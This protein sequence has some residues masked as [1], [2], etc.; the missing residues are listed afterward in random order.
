MRHF[1]VLPFSD[2]GILISWGKK[3]RK[4]TQLFFP[5]RWE[6]VWIVESATRLDVCVRVRVSVSACVCV[7]E[8]EARG[9]QRLHRV[10]WIKQRK[11][12]QTLVRGPFHWWRLEQ[13]PS[14]LSHFTCLKT[15]KEHLASAVLTSSS[16]PPPL[17]LRP[18]HHHHLPPSLFITLLLVPLLHSVSVP[19]PRSALI[20]RW[21]SGIAAHSSE[22]L[23]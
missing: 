20:R 4:V 14:P 10:V 19:L 15:V 17:L 21:Q 22:S 6:I 7:R 8:R 13:T 3:C 12:D 2:G 5:Y 11:V 16:L 18:R 1:P 9:H 23:C